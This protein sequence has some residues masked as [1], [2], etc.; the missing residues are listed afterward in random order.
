[1]L[2]CRTWNQNILNFMLLLTAML[3]KNNEK[4][5]I[6]DRILHFSLFGYLSYKLY[7]KIKRVLSSYKNE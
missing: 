6:F 2:V 4:A 5:V 1:M 3:M 7:N